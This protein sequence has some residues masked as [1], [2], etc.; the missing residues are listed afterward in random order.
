MKKVICILLALSVLLSVAGCAN[1]PI[2]EETALPTVEATE[3]YQ[4]TIPETTEPEAQTL[5]ATEPQPEEIILP[6]EPEAQIPA[7]EVTEGVLFLLNDIPVTCNGQKC[8]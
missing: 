3:E 4:K 6:T 7:Q 8:T 1:T 2:S 5:P